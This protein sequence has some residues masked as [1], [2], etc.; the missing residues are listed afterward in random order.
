MASRAERILLVPDNTL[1]LAFRQPRILAAAGVRVDVLCVEGAAVASSRYVDRVETV[2]DLA[3]L[4]ER[5]GELL[6]GGARD[7]SK[8]V[9]TMEEVVQQLA[10]R[11]EPASLAAWQPGLQEAG[12]RAFIRSKEGLIQ[13]RREWHLP[14]PELHLC[15]DEGEVESFGARIGWPIVT[16]VLHGYGGHGLR[17]LASPAD[18]AR[19]LTG[20]R[21]PV[22][23]QRFVRG[24]RGVVELLCSAGKP[25]AWLAS[26][27]SRRLQ[28]EFSASTGRDFRAMPELDPL[29]RR[30]AE[31][32][33][34]DGFCGFDWMVED[35]T[36]Q[37][38]LIE[39][40]ARAPSGFRFWRDCGVDFPAGVRH[41]LGRGG[42]PAGRHSQSEG[43]VVR[44]AYFPIDLKRCLANRDWSGLRAWLPGSGY[45]HDFPW[46]DLPILFGWVLGGVRRKL[47]RLLRR[48]G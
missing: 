13:A 25:I 9:V 32:T 43:G 8:V 28:G 33:R 21:Y 5:T 31:A 11:V 36:K 17:Y 23:A 19:E 41:W 3:T 20:S 16:K 38:H 46:D 37:I 30:V 27:S 4:V 45:R 2:P 47:A 34:F 42:L 6:G 7:W 10:Q 29:I 24:R 48:R 18:V 15:A 12:V 40:H 39:F 1:Y 44:T 22:L 14:I 35:G 26:F